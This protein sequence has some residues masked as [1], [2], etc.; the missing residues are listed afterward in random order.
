VHLTSIERL[1]LRGRLPLSLE[2]A[3]AACPGAA[4]L[5]AVAVDLPYYHNFP[6]RL[7]EHFTLSEP[8]AARWAERFHG[9]DPRPFARALLEAARSAAPGD[10][11]DARTAFAAGALVHCAFDQVTH[12]VIER[13]VADEGAAGDPLPAWHRHLRIEKWQGLYY[14]LRMFGEDISG[15]PSYL[16]RFRFADRPPGPVAALLRGRALPWPVALAGQ[17]GGAFPVEPGRAFRAACRAAWSDAPSWLALAEWLAG[18]SAYGVLLFSP[19]GRVEGLGRDPAAPRPERA[20]Y[21]HDPDPG[22]GVDFE[23]L[24]E[25]ASARAERYLESAAGY[26]E[27]GELSPDF[28]VPED[29]NGKTV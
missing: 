19:L 16:S 4:R 12:R 2:R 10:A 22:A 20:R 5:G 29:L 11:R 13:R 9:S 8:A 7:A 28:L 26:L 24:V 15:R 27:S 6:R 23:A 3:L 17:M 14:H 1:A 18:L 21:Y 25:E